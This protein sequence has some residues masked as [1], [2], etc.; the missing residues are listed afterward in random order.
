MN[1]S[2]LLVI[3]LLLVDFQLVHSQIEEVNAVDIMRKTFESTREIGALSFTMTKIE[4]IDSELIRQV[5]FCKMIRNPLTVY[6]R[7]EYPNDGLEILFSVGEKV[8]INP[9]GF[10]WINLRL[11]PTGNMV[12]ADQ[13]HTIIESG[14]DHV[15]NVLEHIMIKY[16][17]K[18]N[19]MLFVEK[20]TVWDGY[21]VWKIKLR[22]PYYEVKNYTMQKGETVTQVARRDMLSEYW[23]VEQNEA[24]KSCNDEKP[25]LTIKRPNDYAPSME[26]Y[27]DKVRLIPLVMKIYDLNGLYELYSYIDVK[28]NPIFQDKE[29][30]KDFEAYDF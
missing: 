29:F 18:V 15:M 2:L 28:V 7:Q 11:S 16:A 17:P 27:I 25:G 12:R 14:Y 24:L 10:P 4:R 19:S 22:N 5:S 6:L 21:S 3:F 26:I 13:H 8:L 23:L 30:D 1:R 20:D 9:N